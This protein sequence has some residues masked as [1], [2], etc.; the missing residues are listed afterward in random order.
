MPIFNGQ[1]AAMLHF[2]QTLFRR[3]IATLLAS[4]LLPIVMVGMAVG[5][6]TGIQSSIPTAPAIPSYTQSIAT[7]ELLSSI[8]SIALVIPKASA[9]QQL[10]I[11]NS[12]RTSFA[13][14]DKPNI[15]LV[16]FA[17]ITD[18]QATL[19]N[20][21]RGVANATLIPA[22]L[23]I[24][25]DIP[26]LPASDGL[27]DFQY[28]LFIE[29]NQP[30]GLEPLMIQIADE[31][32]QSLLQ[33]TGSVSFRAVFTSFDFS[34]FYYDVSLTIIP[35]FIV[36]AFAQMIS[37][38]S[39]SRIE[40][41]EK[42]QRDYLFTMGLSPH[43]YYLSA[44]VI[45]MWAY[46][47]SL[48]VSSLI[49][50]G[51]GVKA[52]TQTNYLNWFLPMFCF[53]LLCS[54]LGSCLA[55][56][57][58]KQD[59]AGAAMG[60]GISIVVFVPYFFVYFLAKNV[61]NPELMYVISALLPTFG[62]YQALNAIGLASIASS[63]FDL[64]SLGD[65]QHN[66]VLPLSLIMIVQTIVYWTILTILV[67][68][69]LT[70]S[71]SF[72]SAAFSLAQQTLL[73]VKY[74]GNDTAAIHGDALNAFCENGHESS[75]AMDAELKHEMQ[76]ISNPD[77]AHEDVI[78][79]SNVRVEF[80]RPT[81][82]DKTKKWFM[83]S[84]TERL[85]VLDDMWLAIR[86]NECFAYL[87]PN[88]CGKTTTLNTLIGLVCPTRGYATI[89]LYSILPKYNPHARQIIG[90]CPQFD[91]LWEKLT[92]REHLYT[93]AAIRGMDTENESVKA[94]IDALI[95]DVGLG[96]F[97]E[98]QTGTLSG[99]NKRKISLAMACIG[100]PEVVFLDEPTTGID[101]VIRRSIWSIINKLKQ[102]TSVILTT[103]SM[104]EAEALSDRIGIVVNGRMQCIGTPQRLKS[105]YGCGYKVSIRTSESVDVVNDWFLQNIG[106]PGTWQVARQVGGTTVLQMTKLG[107]EAL[108]TQ[109]LAASTDKEKMIIGLELLEHIFR[110]LELPETCGDSGQ[111]ARQLGIVSHEVQE[112]S[113][114]EVFVA[115][116]S[117]QKGLEL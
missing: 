85:V 39:M 100:K 108:Q 106:K 38:F 7:P 15:Q 99:G 65:F 37:F 50:Y 56:L 6:S 3:N 109:L 68:K 22:A 115:F 70:N 20:T 58:R 28:Q 114:T 32:K 57:F 103:H 45:D 94:E 104:E 61:M 13:A 46:M 97:A 77:L 51:F 81:P 87:G 52:F 23:A 105:V 31:A 25:Q 91:C 96:D 113:M 117:L 67:H 69:D 93:M 21:Y 11:S 1:M 101:I 111:L 59:S 5:I 41:R 62:F 44:F 116:A 36:A 47:I 29:E 84:Q 27:L 55:F 48:V 19:V 73:G 17:S 4:I 83:P 76:R 80:T 71:H 72:L 40:E 79:M 18:Y 8:P 30:K 43:I 78:R 98:K 95:A 10:A 53:G 112:T 74:L 60:L 24:L 88:G 9:A 110:V 86:K 34:G 2:R 102:H 92:P 82:R 33:Q 66:P 64:V 16:S 63:P 12:I 42:K 89:G 26:T 54:P 14:L 90:I 35:T 49:L 75:Q 107:V